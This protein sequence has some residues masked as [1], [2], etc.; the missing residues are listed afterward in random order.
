MLLNNMSRKIKINKSDDWIDFTEGYFR[1]AQ[2]GFGEILKKPESKENLF[3]PSLFN[4]KHAIEMMMKTLSIRYLCKEYLSDTDL[5]HDLDEIFKKFKL[6]IKP[7]RV[8]EAIKQ[9]LSESPE[10]LNK[11]RLTAE[12]IFADLEEI[13]VSYLSLEIIRKKIKPDNIFLKD[14]SNT[15]LRY[16]ANDLGVQLDYK[17]I[18]NEISQDDVKKVLN[19]CVKTENIMWK[20]AAFESVETRKKLEK[21]IEKIETQLNT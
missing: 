16:P 9:F 10:I 1:L 2:L 17:K 7:N 15:A 4:F 19:D 11:E 3:F 14:L 6:D 20:L 13:V 5:S 12:Y 18:L 8:N 21:E